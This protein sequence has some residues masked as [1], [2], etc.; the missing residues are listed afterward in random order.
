MVKQFHPDLDK[1]N[2]ELFKKIN[3]AYEILGNESTRNEYN[4]MKANPTSNKGT[5]YQQ[6]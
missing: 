5:G 4:E 1:N 3:E 2:E 6:T